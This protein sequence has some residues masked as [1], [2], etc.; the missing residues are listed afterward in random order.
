MIEIDVSGSS[1]SIRP[2]E[3]GDNLFIPIIKDS[4]NCIVLLGWLLLSWHWVFYHYCIL[5]INKDN[6]RKI[7]NDQV[8][9]LYGSGT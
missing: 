2:T 8:V 1:S 3:E 6:V 5:L 7:T 4:K 9:Q